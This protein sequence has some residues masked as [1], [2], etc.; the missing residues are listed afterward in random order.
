[1]SIPR[2]LSSEHNS[3]KVIPKVFWAV[4]ASLEQQYDPQADYRSSEC[5]LRNSLIPVNYISLR[6]LVL[7]IFLNIF[8]VFPNKKIILKP[9][10]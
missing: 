2:V 5:L 3:K 10:Y 1:M 4:T 9:D 8:R 7:S 6:G